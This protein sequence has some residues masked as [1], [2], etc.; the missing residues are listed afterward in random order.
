MG[1]GAPFGQEVRNQ[2]QPGQ[3]R[4]NSGLELLSGE[5]HDPLVGVEQDQWC[6]FAESTTCAHVGGYH[7]TTPISHRYIVRP[8][9]GLKVPRERS[10]W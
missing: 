6:S 8:T 3:I 9:Q 2:I 7:Q 1:K 5:E 4:S 10:V